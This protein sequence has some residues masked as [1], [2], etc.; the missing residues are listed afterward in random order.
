[1]ADQDE[2]S[3][4]FGAR[5]REL[6]QE[7][8]RRLDSFAGSAGDA[9]RLSRIERGLVSPTLRSVE[10]LAQDL[11][12]DPVDL[13]IDPEIL[14]HKLIAASRDASHDRLV[15]ALKALAPA[16]RRFSKTYKV[17]RTRTLRRPARVT[18]AS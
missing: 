9:G 13:L 15:R 12:V 11:D 10:L 1:V 6:R 8:G 16:K 18:K 17:G 14:R 4:R 5:L 2:L 7:S 3:K